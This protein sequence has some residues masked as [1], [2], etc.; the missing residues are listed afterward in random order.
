MPKTKPR[1]LAAVTAMV[2]AAAAA[3]SSASLLFC[4]WLA[5]LGGGECGFKCPKLQEKLPP[6]HSWCGCT[7]LEGRPSEAANE[8]AN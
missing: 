5:A 7:V 8:A 6:N 3:S 1:M 4:C 2:V